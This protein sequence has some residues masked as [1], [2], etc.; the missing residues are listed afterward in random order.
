MVA[1]FDKQSYLKYTATEFNNTLL[2][3][4][5]RFYPFDLSGTILRRFYDNCE[6]CDSIKLI[7][8]DFHI[9][10]I[11]IL[12]GHNVTLLSSSTINVRNTIKNYY[13]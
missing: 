9:L 13:N 12:R 5:V 7:L 3:I 2:H 8:T 4:N 10:L 6:D 1:T 11:A